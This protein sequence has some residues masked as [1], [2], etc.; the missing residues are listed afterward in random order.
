MSESENKNDYPE[1]CEA[2]HIGMLHFIA[3]GNDPRDGANFTLLTFRF[4][5]SLTRLK[6]GLTVVVQYGRL[7]RMIPGVKP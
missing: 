5:E 6:N 7:Y 3:K 2:C 1:M 4:C